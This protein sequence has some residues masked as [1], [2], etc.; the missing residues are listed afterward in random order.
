VHTDELWAF[1]IHVSYGS[2]NMHIFGYTYRTYYFVRTIVTKKTTDYEVVPWISCITFSWTGV[3]LWHEL[4][5]NVWIDAC[6]DI[7]G[8]STCAVEPQ[9]SSKHQSDSGGSYAISNTEKMFRYIFL[10]AKYFLIKSGNYENIGLAKAK[11]VWSSPPATEA[12]LNR[13]FQ[14]FWSL[15][16]S[17]C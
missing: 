9:P 6:L 5:K 7:V 13:A 2:V 16:I 15:G 3:H 17:L 12:K 10:D 4:T 1:S 8:S 14:V 11:G